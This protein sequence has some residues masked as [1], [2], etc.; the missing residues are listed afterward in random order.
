MGQASDEAL[1]DL[2]E[3]DAEGRIHPPHPGNGH[4]KGKDGLRVFGGAS[5][6]RAVVD[7]KEA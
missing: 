5:P 3:E 7:S 2:R 4:R 1:S 6:K